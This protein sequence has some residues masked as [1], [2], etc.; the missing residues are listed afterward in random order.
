MDNIIVILICSSLILLANLITYK[1]STDDSFIFIL[2]LNFIVALLTLI[3]I[4]YHYNQY[5][6]DKSD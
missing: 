6:L 3:F 2:R 5:I 1:R 4:I